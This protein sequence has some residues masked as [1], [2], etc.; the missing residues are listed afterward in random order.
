VSDVQGPGG[1]GRSRGIRVTPATQPLPTN[2]SPP[3]S[4]TPQQLRNIIG[5]L[6]DP[7]AL[8]LTPIERRKAPRGGLQDQLLEG[9]FS[10]LDQMPLEERAK[11]LTVLL[12]GLSGRKKLPKEL[13]GVGLEAFDR[14][15]KINGTPGQGR[16]YFHHQESEIAYALTEQMRSG[17]SP[18]QSVEGAL[19]KYQRWTHRHEPESL[20]KDLSDPERNFLSIYYRLEDT[21]KNK[22]DLGLSKEQTQQ[23]TKYLGQRMGTKDFDSSDLTLARSVWK[24]IDPSLND[25]QWADQLTRVVAGQLKDGPSQE[26]TDSSGFRDLS[27]AHGAATGES[28]SN[29]LGQMRELYRRVDHHH[30]KDAL[31]SDSSLKD[32]HGYLVP[33]KIE[34]PSADPFYRQIERMSGTEVSPADYKDALANL[35]DQKVDPAK[36]TGFYS[37]AYKKTGDAQSFI[38]PLLKGDDP[39]GTKALTVAYAATEQDK[40]YGYAEGPV[41][42]SH[43]VKM[44]GFL[45]THKDNATAR[46]ASVKI[47][48]TLGR[49]SSEKQLKPTPALIQAM[50]QSSTSSALLKTGQRLLR[51]GR[52]TPQQREQVQKV[53]DRSFQSIPEVPT[54][55]GKKNPADEELYSLG[56]QLSAAV[57]VGDSSGST[58]LRKTFN[59]IVKKEG[60]LP[61]GDYLPDWLVRQNNIWTPWSKL[62]ESP[63]AYS[64]SNPFGEVE[65]RGSMVRDFVVAARKVPPERKKELVSLLGDLPTTAWKD[66]P[67]GFAR[68]TRA[69]R[70]LE[71]ESVN[72]HGREESRAR[73]SLTDNYLSEPE[74]RE[75][76]QAFREKRA[77][78]YQAQTRHQGLIGRYQAADSLGN[79]FDTLAR[80]AHDHELKPEQFD[81]LLMGAGGL[82]AEKHKAGMT[83]LLALAAQKDGIAPADLQVV[84]NSYRDFPADLQQK[85]QESKS[86]KEAMELVSE[87]FS[88]QMR[89]RVAEPKSGLFQDYLHEDKGEEIGSFLIRQ[90]HG[91]SLMVDPKGGASVIDTLLTESTHNPAARM[92]GRHLLEQL[93]KEPGATGRLARLQRV[94]FETRR[95][96]V[97]DKKALITDLGQLRRPLS[98]VPESERRIQQMVNLE[99]SITQTQ[100]QSGRDGYNIQ[101]LQ[102]VLQGGK[103]LKAQVQGDMKGLP[104]D[105]SQRPDLRRFN[106]QL[107]AS[108]QILEA[109]EIRLD[110]SL[111]EQQKEAKLRE[112]LQLKDGMNHRAIRGLIGLAVDS[113]TDSVY[114]GVRARVGVEVRV[115]FLGNV[116]AF[117]EGKA[118]FDVTM[119]ES[120]RVS[121]SFNTKIGVGAEAGSDA[122]K[123]SASGSKGKYRKN[124]LVFANEDEAAKFIQDVMSQMDLVEKPPPFKDPIAIATN[125]THTKAEVNIRNV[126]VSYDRKDET[127]QLRSRVPWL[128]AG[129]SQGSEIK[130]ITE[131]ASATIK[132]KG[133][134]WG[135]EISASDQIGSRNQTA[136]G[137]TL[138]VAFQAG[139]GAKG[140]GV[141]GGGIQRLADSPTDAFI[142]NLLESAKQ[143]RPEL[144][145][146]LT[147]EQARA[148]LLQGF[149][150][151]DLKAS[152]SAK[153]RLEVTMA[154]PENLM[155]G[156]DNN[157]MDVM[158]NFAENALSS[159]D[160]RTKWSFYNLRTARE[161]EMDASMRLSYG[162]GIKVYAELGLEFRA[163]DA[164]TL[165]GSHYHARQVLYDGMDGAAFSETQLDELS[166]DG[167]IHRFGKDKGTLDKEAFVTNLGVMRTELTSLWENPSWRDKHARGLNREQF[168]TNIDDYL[169]SVS[170]SMHAGLRNHGR[171][172]QSWEQFQQDISV[173]KIRERSAQSA[174]SVR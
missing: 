58:R 59:E 108:R 78:R 74:R 150:H 100:L 86:P 113:P 119:A 152:V 62:D 33:S 128:P 12:T 81:K 27:E 85:L 112:S 117:V 172:F 61:D 14:V 105:L 22:G 151:A 110:Q 35:Q 67:I 171:N 24:K 57:R 1:I 21:L 50:E 147:D 116:G 45:A 155:Q 95:R 96:Y 122:A 149:T 89:Q 173:A 48:D 20:V 114:L 83:K 75:R 55:L 102:D 70:D 32:V 163:R 84:L 164:T 42:P 92:G 156:T 39:E 140:G 120:G 52:L 63:D 93:E 34:S 121:V 69:L 68:G 139:V 103:A 25:N 77:E 123:V 13:V 170:R 65:Q 167:L 28:K 76:E 106:G 29:L 165:A 49:L 47:F 15:N 60:G 157:A 132:A 66:N 135:L 46:A 36:L 3:G 90:G 142:D 37:D 127:S 133:I 94:Q 17:S 146:G 8:G 104:D 161:L 131:T 111:S 31:T 162:A 11:A 91:E 56:N 148:R 53:V 51:E 9:N 64:P 107:E 166:K 97:S 101:S 4:Q 71:M 109:Q 174:V 44:L 137:T 16:S 19:E 79:D 7:Q 124:T 138:T 80:Y 153:G 168:E 136:N 18:S 145:E 10:A 125:G 23:L 5:D 72:S 118:G 41:D 115:P 88:F 141:D 99:T 159:K 43:S 38:A 2:H 130:S 160:G 30:Y 154:T 126:N 158:M 134:E 6:S 40:L 87:R 26:F 143:M 144:L 129:Q 73:F 82:A 98:E 169:Q 54:D